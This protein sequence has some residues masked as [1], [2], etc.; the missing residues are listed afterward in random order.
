V[1]YTESSDPNKLLG[2]PN[3]YVTKANFSDSRLTNTIEKDGCSI[4]SF[5]KQGDLEAR[6]KYTEAI[7]KAGGPFAQYIYSHKNIL[8]RLSHD[9]TP[10]Q[11]AQYEQILKTL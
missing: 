1:I 4:E 5:A 11:A 6:R 3:Q 10:E 8:L 9:I 2:R 7:S